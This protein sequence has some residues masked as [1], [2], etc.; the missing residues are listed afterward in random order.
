M[1]TIPI[2]FFLIIYF[3]I[4]VMLTIFFT[5]NFFHIILTGTTTFSSFLATLFV[6]ASIALV[7][8]GTWYFLQGINWSQTITIWDNSWF[9]QSFNTI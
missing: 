6:F 4:L 5:V 1:I 7:L 8:F 3:V 9:G 2:S